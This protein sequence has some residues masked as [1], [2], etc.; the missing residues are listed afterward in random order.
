MAKSAQPQ[1]KPSQPKNW[2]Q[3]HNYAFVSERPKSL[4]LR[5]HLIPYVG[6]PAGP[7]FLRGVY[8]NVGKESALVMA[9]S[10]AFRMEKELLVIRTWYELPNF[11]L[12][13]SLIDRK[14]ALDSGY[15]HLD[16][17]KNTFK[18]EVQQVLLDA[19]PP[20]AQAL[21]KS[22]SPAEICFK[23]PHLVTLL[24]RLFPE[25]LMIVHPVR[26]DFPVPKDAGGKEPSRAVVTAATMRDNDLIRKSEV[27][28]L[29]NDIA[30]D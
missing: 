3:V 5:D 7:G 28:Y 21:N 15:M 1:F 19:L 18:T 10:A 17:L 11:G 9:D 23:Y 30:V 20:E 8:G 6:A 14:L 22:S 24:F 2:I 25:V 29:E 13:N 4:K 27:Q 16:R 12:V 26:L